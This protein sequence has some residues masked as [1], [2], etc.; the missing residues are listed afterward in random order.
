MK[1]YIYV[2]TEKGV[3]KYIDD[4][5]ETEKIYK[6]AERNYINGVLRCS[7]RIIISGNIP[8]ERKKSELI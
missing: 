7:I 4:L 8:V 6:K 2:F 5:K 1:I 3:E